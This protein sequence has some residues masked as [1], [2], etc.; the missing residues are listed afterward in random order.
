MIL[1][2]AAGASSLAPHILLREAGLG[3]SLESVDLATKRW[4][5]G[6]FDMINPKSYVPA[7][8]TSDG[9][10]LTECAVILQY[11]A[12]QA[13]DRA[14]MPAFSTIERYRAM[15]WLNY[16]ATELHKNFITPERH[17]DRAAN[18]LAKS[19]AGQEAT[20]KLVSPRLAF[21]NGALKGRAFL[22]GPHFSA[23]D[24]YLFAML[25]WAERLDLDL[26]EW[27]NLADY[28][29]RLAQRPAVVQTMSVEGP[30]HSLKDDT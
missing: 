17:G 26:A 19:A 5:G 14:L 13:Q 25:T 4:S 29:G 8:K 18:F 15:E 21:V 16:I 9:E 6:D 24:A 2:Y 20:R 30:P 23:P 1:F 10:V 22:M 28:L 7:L 27:P 11:V 12:D 3:F